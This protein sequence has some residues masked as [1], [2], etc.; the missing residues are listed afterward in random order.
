MKNAI[1]DAFRIAERRNA[2][3]KRSQRVVGRKDDVV[4]Q[5]DLEIGE[6]ITTILFNLK[7]GLVIES[8]EHGKQTNI[9]DENDEAYYIAIDDIDGTNNYRVGDGMLPYCSMVV[10]FDGKNKKDGAY[11]YSDY[12][13]AAC[14]DYTT[15]T[16]FYTEKGLGRV[17]KYD[18]D[19]NRLGDSTNMKQDNT[20]LAL[21]L[22][23]DVVS[24]Q[25]GGS[26]GYA[27]GKEDT[28]VAVLPDELSIVYR[29]F[30]IVDSACSVF[31]YAMV[32][33]GIRNGYVSSGKKEHELPL[34]Y[35]FAKEAGLKMVDFDGKVYDDRTYNF[36]GNNAEVIVGSEYVVNKVIN[37]IRR[38]RIANKELA[39]TYAKVAELKKERESRKVEEAGEAIG[40]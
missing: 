32:G 27:A 17:E 40:E 30:G 33:M 26:V 29:N 28:D 23:T 25:R 36:N 38:Q 9:T 22:S 18:L 2:G 35:A 21:T 3:L 12:L 4:T 15:K 6:A 5:G 14:I 13:Y 7:D 19:G 31:E 11:K 34:L 39:D 37:C 16:I 1:F 20:G 24:T 8:E 10:V